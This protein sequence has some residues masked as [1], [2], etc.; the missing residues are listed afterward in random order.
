[1]R[2]TNCDQTTSSDKFHSLGGVCKINASDLKLANSSN[3]L[4]GWANT[5]LDIAQNESGTTIYNYKHAES[6]EEYY[7]YGPQKIIAIK[8]KEIVIADD[9]A[10]IENSTMSQK[11]RVV[12]FNLETNSITGVKTSPTEFYFSTSS[13]TYQPN[14][15]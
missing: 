11:N 14:N 6:E 9:G 10:S 3:P 15:Q 12:L 1:M 5:E 7:F 8:P 13:G 4:I 2:D